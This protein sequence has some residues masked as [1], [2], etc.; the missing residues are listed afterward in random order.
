MSLEVPRTGRR[1]DIVPDLALDPALKTRLVWFAVESGLPLRVA[2]AR[3]LNFYLF[4][5]RNRATVDTLFAILRLAEALGIAQLTGDAVHGYLTAKAELTKYG[6]SFED[7]PEALRLL[8]LLGNLPKAWTWDGARAAIQNVR[9]IL[10]ADI[11]GQQIEVFLDHHQ[12]LIEWGFDAGTG[13]AIVKA[14]AE[15]G[16]TGERRDLVIRALVG[17]ASAQVDLEALA[18]R[19]RDLE[20][21]V[22]KLEAERNELKRRVKPLKTRVANLQAAAVA[23]VREQERLDA[24]CRARETELSSLRGL[25]AVLLGKTAEVGPFLNDVERLLQLRRHGRVPDGE[26][27][28]RVADLRFKVIEFFKQIVAE[29]QSA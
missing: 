20:A 19:R 26:Y 17:T 15:G 18:E 16:A 3:L 24:E 1:D 28:A 9:K 2:L 25:R 5:R 6:C 21:E 27:A 8:D 7:I 13:V 4:W 11:D 29:G 14:L 22:I 10:L 12:Q 23:A